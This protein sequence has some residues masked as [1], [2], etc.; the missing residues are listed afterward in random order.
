MANGYTV[1]QY[2]DMLDRSKREIESQ[3]WQQENNIVILKTSLDRKRMRLNMIKE[4]L[5]EG[6]QVVEKTG[7]RRLV[8]EASL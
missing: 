5:K 6:K 3:I 2:I 4:E 1:R 7:V 8:R